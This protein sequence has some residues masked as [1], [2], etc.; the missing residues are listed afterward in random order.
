MKKLFFSFLG[1]FCG[2][3]ENDGN[4]SLWTRR[5][6]HGRVCSGRSGGRARGVRARSPPTRAYCFITV[7][8][9]DTASPDSLRLGHG[10]GAAAGSEERK[11]DAFMSTNVLVGPA[12]GR[13]FIHRRVTLFTCGK[14]G[15]STESVHCG[16]YTPTTGLIEVSMI[17][18][19]N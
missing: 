18:V 19:L 8:S 11:T 16:S 6:L 10:G 13:G 17:Q 14:Y 12:A 3:A 4:H 15:V 7:Q 1:G 9:S 5:S 2:G